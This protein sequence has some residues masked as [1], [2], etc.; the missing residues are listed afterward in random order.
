MAS[1]KRG[2][3]IYQMETGFEIC[4]IG[5]KCNNLLIDRNTI[6]LYTLDMPLEKASVTLV[7]TAVKKEAK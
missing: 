3:Y 2:I 7:E 1:G 6:T 4:E 5:S